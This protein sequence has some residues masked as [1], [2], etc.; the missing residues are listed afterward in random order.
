VFIP[1]AERQTLCVSTQV[2]CAM[3]CA[4]CA[5]AT[6]GLIRSLSAG[7]ITG[8]VEAAALR[9]GGGGKAGGGKA[10]PISN[11]VF[12][13]MGEPLAN[14]P[15]VGAAVQILLHPAG[16]GLSR[17]HITVSTA[18]LVP[19]MEEF[20]HRLPVKLA[21][22]LNATTD[23]VR[24]RLM[25]INR[26]F[27]IQDL[28]ACCRQLP[29]QHGD[30]LTFEYVLLGGINDGPED[31]GRLAGL[32]QGIRAKV[33][34]IPFNT[35]PGC[36][37]GAPDPRAVEAFQEA[38]VTRQLSAFVRQSRGESLQGACGQLVTGRHDQH[39]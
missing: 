24:D 1:E 17:R 18:G 23:A 16:M 39:D 22:S 33:N 14:L 5:T 37:F 8:Q 7:E 26:R 2:G 12:M 10:R 38:L 34:L 21:I 20:V 3:G 35:F 29:L 15:A 9:L 28:L 31:A 19:A 6:M 11:V 32:L 25:P 13:G 30:R 36:P 27:P 4:F